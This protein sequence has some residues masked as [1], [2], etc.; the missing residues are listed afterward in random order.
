MVRR[1]YERTVLGRPAAGARGPSCGN[2]GVR[3]LAHGRHREHAVTFA[4]TTSEAG[5][6]G[7]ASPGF[8]RGRR[9]V[10]AGRTESE[11]GDRIFAHFDTDLWW[12]G[13]VLAR[14]GPV[15]E[16]RYHVVFDDGESR[17]VWAADVSDAPPPGATL[18]ASGPNARARAIVAESQGTS[19]RRRADVADSRI[20]RGMASIS[21]TSTFSQSGENRLTKTRRII[22]RR[23]Y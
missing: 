16:T 14:S 20:C 7:A 13:T 9:R 3:A 2:R 1:V 19:K 8:R 17:S 15:A 23:S 18:G 11:P 10:G 22:I 5:L 6:P 21:L 4:I 12:G